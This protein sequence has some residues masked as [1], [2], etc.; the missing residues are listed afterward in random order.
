MTPE[1]FSAI[2]KIGRLRRCPTTDA[3][4]MHLVEGVPLPEAARRSGA[5]YT[6]AWHA[7]R[8]VRKLLALARIAA[9]EAA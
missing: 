1:A 4:R 6:S 8:R 2:A 5:R 7:V 9:S 3:V